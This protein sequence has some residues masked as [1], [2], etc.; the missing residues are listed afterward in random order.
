MPTSSLSFI[1]NHQQVLQNQSTGGDRA[2]APTILIKHHSLYNTGRRGRRP[3]QGYRWHFL[4]N[5]Y[6]KVKKGNFF[7]KKLAICGK[8]LYNKNDGVYR[9][10]LE[11]ILVVR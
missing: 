1:L 6:N 11:I 3:L 10:I 9:L 8:M 5:S 2:A 7:P 4:S